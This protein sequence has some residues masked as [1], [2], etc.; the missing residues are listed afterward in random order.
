[1]KHLRKTLCES[2]LPL[3]AASIIGKAFD[4]ENDCALYIEVP[5]ETQLRL[6]PG[7][8]V[9]LFPE[10]IHRPGLSQGVPARVRKVVVKVDKELFRENEIEKRHS[11][12]VKRVYAKAQ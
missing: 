6:I 1:M 2:S 3:W 11:F 7:M 12:Y 10:D 8:L 4:F 5:N 9:V